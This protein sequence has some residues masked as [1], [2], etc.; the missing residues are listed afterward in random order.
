MDKRESKIIAGV[1]ILL[2]ILLHTVAGNMFETKSMIVP[3]DIM[4]AIARFGKICVSLYAFVSGYGL[5]IAY[6][7]N[8]TQEANGIGKKI[9]LVYKEAIKRLFRFYVIYWPFV[10]VGA[11]LTFVFEGSFSVAT[12]VK[13][14]IGWDFAYNAA[15]WYVRYYVIML[16][17]LY[18]GTILV[19]EL[20]FKRFWGA[21]QVGLMAV[22]M[23]VMTVGCYV[24]G[25]RLTGA[26]CLT[27]F[28]V[29][30]ICAECNTLAY[31]REK[32]HLTIVFF[33]VGLL[34]RCTY[35]NE[36]GTLML[37]LLCVPMMI[38]AVL[39][40]CKYVKPMGRLLY[41]IGIHSTTMWLMHTFLYKYSDWPERYLPDGIVGWI[42][43]TVLAYAVATV[44]DF[45]YIRI[46]SI[47][48]RV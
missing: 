39:E 40:V 10:I 42:V 34:M 46:R 41:I 23:A 25:N 36:L 35:T 30:E 21:F 31:I 38:P 48:K 45:L 2:M 24:V 19:Y 28:L 32:R 17:V 7:A 16:L 6:K 8:E 27:V 43:I 12:F 22:L 13:N 4:T 47:R 44:W 26:L 3:N 20:F 9:V 15:W 18:P 11:V 14:A 5:W 37:D 1:A 29:G 33:V